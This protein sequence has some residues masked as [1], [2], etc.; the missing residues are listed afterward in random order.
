MEQQR[1]E[2]VDDGGNERPPGSLEPRDRRRL[3]EQ[4]REQNDVRRK[5]TEPVREVCIG[6]SRCG[7]PRQLWLEPVNV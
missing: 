7:R 5:R 4:A 6:T 3:V 2:V 1:N